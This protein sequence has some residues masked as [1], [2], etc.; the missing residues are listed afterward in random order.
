MN[1]NSNNKI[2]KNVLITGGAG[3]IG[4][5]VTETLLKKN[6]KVFLVDNLS[7]GHKKLINKKAK[8]FKLDIAN[9]HGI[10][11][12]IEKY[13]IDSIIH[14]AAHLIIGEG[15][16]KPKKYYKNNVLGTKK[17]MEA[18]KNSTVKNFIFSSTAAIYKEGQ[19]KV[20]EN[21]MIKP[22]S[23]YGKTK[24]KAE[25]LIINFAKKNKINYGI[26]RYFNIAGA[27]PSGKIGLINKKS[28]HLFKNFSSEIMKKRPKLKIYGSDYKTKDGS[29]IR[30]F[31]HVSDI[32]QIHYLILE[33]INKLKI[34]KILNCGYN[35]G[36]SV[37]EVAK[38][39]KKQSSKKVNI[40][41]TKRRKD[42]LIKIIA[43]NKKLKNFVKWRPKFDNLSKIVKSCIIWERKIR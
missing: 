5:H 33:K 34:S 18:C 19:Y 41:F 35:K 29:C 22:K 42:D 28:D 31:I 32:A 43:S 11:K 26:L 17:L 10:K 39:F 21:S 9:K 30:D 4:S 6:K 15:Q 36:I 8:F 7:T 3:Y 38:E 37:L 24:I 25:N 12:I 14:L 1:N 20:S 40:I 13:K 27:S 16:K 23:V 2:V